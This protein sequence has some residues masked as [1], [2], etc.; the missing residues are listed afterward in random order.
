MKG[1]Q[2]LN[3]I[4]QRNAVKASSDRSNRISVLKSIDTNVR[5]CYTEHIFEKLSS[6]PDSFRH[7]SFR[8]YVTLFF[9]EVRY[10]NPAFANAGKLLQYMATRDGV[11][12]LPKGIDNAPATKQQVNLFQK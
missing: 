12:K 8:Q 6:L 7:I 5:I 9:Q 3:R 1:S 10:G 2:N 11:E 4:K